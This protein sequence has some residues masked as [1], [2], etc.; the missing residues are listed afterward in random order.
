MSCFFTLQSS[1]PGNI[2]NTRHCSADIFQSKPILV[3]GPS[4]HSRLV[5]KPKQN[6]DT[7]D[8]IYMRVHASDAYLI[9]ALLCQYFLCDIIQVGWT[10]W[11]NEVGF[12]S[13][14]YDLCQSLAATRP[15]AI[16]FLRRLF[17]Q[18]SATV[19]TICRSQSSE[20]T[21]SSKA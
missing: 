18:T 14:V 8:F 13:E 11:E 1:S 16:V 5:R 7:I 12:P 17:L 21:L 9:H 6:L 15:A 10:F 20:V 19:L 3:I 4:G 2:S